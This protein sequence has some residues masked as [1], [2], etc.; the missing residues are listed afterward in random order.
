LRISTVNNFLTQKT[1][2]INDF[3]PAAQAQGQL[4]Q[5]MINV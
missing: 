3:A 2:K 5:I 4:L 1:P